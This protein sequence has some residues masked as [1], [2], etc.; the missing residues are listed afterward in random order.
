MTEHV[1]MAAFKKIL[2]ESGDLYTVDDILAE[3][4]DGRMQSFNVGESWVVTKVVNY[5]N[6]KVLDI[7]AAAGTLAELFEAQPIVDAFAREHACEAIMAFGRSGWE[8]I[9]TDG[10]KKVGHT[11]MREIG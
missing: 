9:M 1:N 5:P 8:R 4:A 6:K 11:Y 3:I 2:V 7:V 10:W